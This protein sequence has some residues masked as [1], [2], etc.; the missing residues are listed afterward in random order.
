MFVVWDKLI[1][2]N[3]GGDKLGSAIIAISR[4]QLAIS[5][6]NHLA[7]SHMISLTL[8]LSINTFV[9]PTLDNH[10]RKKQLI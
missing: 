9:S 7:H 2:D 10:M 5:L 6:F 1:G 8:R 4:I 3:C